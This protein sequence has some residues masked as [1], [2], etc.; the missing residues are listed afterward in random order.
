MKQLTNQI[1]LKTLLPILLILFIGF[2]TSY[3]QALTQQQISAIEN[4]IISEMKTAHTP[5][6]ALLMKKLLDWPTPK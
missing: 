4:T 3:A 6:T 1:M 2:E 5:G